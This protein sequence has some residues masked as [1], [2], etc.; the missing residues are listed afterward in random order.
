[1]PSKGKI[2]FLRFIERVVLFLMVLLVGALAWLS[3]EGKLGVQESYA[4]GGTVILCIL[5]TFFIQRKIDN[6]LIIASAQ[7][8][9]LHD[10]AFT[11]LYE[12][13]PVA[14][15]TVDKDGRIVESNPAAVKLLEGEFATIG[16]V[17]LFSRLQS[18]D[19]VDAS[20]LASKVSSGVVMNDVELAITTLQDQVV[21]VLLSVF[22]SR[23][24]GQFLV[25]L[26]DVTEQKQVDTAKSEFVA[27]ATHQLRTPIAAIR[28]NVELLQKSMRDSKTEKQTRYLSKI[29]RN[30]MRTLNLINDFLS[31]SKLEMGTYA[32]ES[33]ELDLTEFFASIE[34]EFAEKITNKQITLERDYRP[35]QVVV[36][37]DRRLFH[38]I[39]SNL[40]SNAVKYLG[41][42]GTLRL[43][44]RV[45]GNEL[46]MEVADNGIGIPESEIGNLFTKFFRATNAQSHQTEGTG[47]GLY[48]VR[49]SVELLNGQITVQ[50][51][52]NQGARFVV[53][54]P[55]VVVSATDI[56]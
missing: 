37:A 40:V 12:R 47:L 53:T 1:M 46:T 29:D 45:A 17:N 16:T 38:I 54:L 33:I 43:S 49:Q 15:V 25:S 11:A 31:V 42:Q 51:A 14:Y 26:V 50:S 36:K 10:D 55:A 56:G 13:S 28:W 35:S 41:A 4:G 48:V 30:V 34:E 32:A 3:A 7:T 6:W 23:T 5:L 21:W 27:L 20:L 24:R 8:N 52:E 39:V 18:N 19:A 2:Q 44:Y 22:P 9:Y